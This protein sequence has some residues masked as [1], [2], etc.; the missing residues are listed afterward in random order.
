MREEEEI[1]ATLR[2]F[3]FSPWHSG[4]GCMVYRMGLD[5][6]DGDYPMITIINGFGAIPKRYADSAVIGYY[7][8][9][10]DVGIC[11]YWTSMSKLVAHLRNRHGL[12]AVTQM[13]WDRNAGHIVH[14]LKTWPEYFQAIDS[15]LKTFEIRRDDREYNVGDLLNLREWDADKQEF[16]NSPPLLRRVTYIMRGFDFG[17]RPGF[18]ALGIE[19]A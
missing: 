19:K 13:V 5:E 3:G 17:L 4:G 7:V 12:G 9:P 1:K 14:S 15:G 11:E 2:E 6:R 16:T 18:V 10:E 8:H